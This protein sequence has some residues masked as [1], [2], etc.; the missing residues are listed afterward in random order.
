MRFVPVPG[1][2]IPTHDMP[3]LDHDANLTAWLDRQIFSPSH[4]Y[5]HT[6]DPEGLLSTIPAVA[7]GLIGLLTGEWLRTSRTLIEKARGIAIAGISQRPLSEPAWDP[8]FPVSKKLWT[9]SFILF[10]AG[11]SLL[12]MAAS[13]YVVDVLRLRIGP[14]ATPTLPSPPRIR[15]SIVR[16]WSSA[17]TPSSRT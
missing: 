7:T 4:L 10:A 6:R 11:S 15:C 8:L 3:I 14:A 9:S 2:G 12:L 16:C 1:Y 5:E 17:P 13:I